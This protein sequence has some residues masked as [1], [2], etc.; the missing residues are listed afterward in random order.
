MMHVVCCY[1]VFTRRSRVC[2][3]SCQM[4]VCWLDSLADTHWWVGLTANQR[5]MARG[6]ILIF[7]LW[8]ECQ[9]ALGRRREL[10]SSC[11]RTKRFQTQKHLQI[12]RMSVFRT[13]Q[14]PCR[15]ESQQT[16]EHLYRCQPK[17]PNCEQ[18]LLTLKRAKPKSQTLTLR[19]WST[20]MLWLLMSLCTISIACIY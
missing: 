3:R 4:S 11:I 9:L 14:G 19:F 1:L 13:V 15:W 6:A 8:N 12:S 7:L 2:S 10:P 17:K 5:Q 20:S 18:L 16:E